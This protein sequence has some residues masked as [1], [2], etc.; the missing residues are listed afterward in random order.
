MSDEARQL[1]ARYASALAQDAGSD[2]YLTGGASSSEAHEAVLDHIE[3]I[4]RERDEARETI[5]DL[6]VLLEAKGLTTQLQTMME[7]RIATLEA[8][9]ARLRAN[10]ERYEYLRSH[11]ED[12]DG[13][14]CFPDVRYRNGLHDGFEARTVDAAI[15]AAKEEK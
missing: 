13:H 1:V 10:A 4:E 5:A 7:Q 14:V 9:N 2:V 6:S 8:E 12:Y 15:D 11:A 3:R